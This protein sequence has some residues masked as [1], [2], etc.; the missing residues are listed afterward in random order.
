[1]KLGGHPHHE[2]TAI[3]FPSQ[4]FRYLFAVGL[5]IFNDIGHYLADSPFV[6]DR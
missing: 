1:M 4:W 6:Y 3:F 5:H 2:T